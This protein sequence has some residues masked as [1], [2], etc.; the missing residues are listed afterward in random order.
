MTAVDYLYLAAT[1]HLVGEH[2]LEQIAYTTY[3]YLK[4]EI[5][6]EE[7]GKAAMCGDTLTA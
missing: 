3:R 7:M 5:K 2:E 6:H 4:G 1:Y